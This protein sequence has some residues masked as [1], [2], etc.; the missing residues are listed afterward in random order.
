MNTSDLVPVFSG[1]IDGQPAQLVNARDLHQ[2]L[3]SHREYTAWIKDRIEQYG[4]KEGEDF[5]TKLSKSQ[6]RPRTDYHVT[7]DTAKELAMVERN[8]KGRQ[9]RRYFIEC[10][11][12]AQES[13]GYPP[14][15]EVALS[16][17]LHRMTLDHHERARALLTGRIRDYRNLG[18][19]D[20]EIAARFDREPLDKLGLVRTEDLNPVLGRLGDL[21]NL[22]NELADPGPAPRLK[23][24]TH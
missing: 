4:F 20:A 10:E 1:E 16:R 9:A 19:S 22:I 17:R 15:L 24:P 12:R 11:R 8:E 13:G 5:L 18:Y 7:L 14:E 6:G 3:E 23:R 2:F 21:F